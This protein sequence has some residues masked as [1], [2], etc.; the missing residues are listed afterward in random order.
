MQTIVEGY[1]LGATFDPSSPE[2]IARAVNELLGSGFRIAADD[3]ARF[4]HDFS[5]KNEEKTLLGIFSSLQKGLDS[6]A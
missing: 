2:D 5:W 6:L 1:H 4:R 3:L